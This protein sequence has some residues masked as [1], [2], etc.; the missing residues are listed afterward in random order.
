MK[1]PRPPAWY[2]I[3]AMAIPAIKNVKTATKDR[4]L[5]LAKPQRPW[6]LVHPL[7]NFVPNPTNIPARANPNWDVEIVI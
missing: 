5:S 4:I 6:P 7:D 2:I 1:G 3:V